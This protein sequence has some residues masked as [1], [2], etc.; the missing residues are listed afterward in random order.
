M[1]AFVLL[2]GQVDLFAQGLHDTCQ[3]EPSGW[4][5][6]AGRC[7]SSAH[8][9]GLHAPRPDNEVSVQGIM[10]QIH[11][12][13]RLRKGARIERERLGR[14]SIM[15]R[16]RSVAIACF[17]LCAAAGCPMDAS[18]GTH[19]HMQAHFDA[20]VAVRDALIAG[21]LDEARAK[22]RWI[23]ENEAEPGIASWGQYVAE[24]RERAAE[25]V[26]ASG[27]EAAAAASAEL[28]RACG[29]CHAGHAVP[30]ELGAAEPPPAASGRVPHMLRH[31]WAAE[32]MWEGL[33]GPSE[34]RWKTGAA[35]L[36]EAPLGS[37][38]ILAE[39]SAAPRITELADQV[40][41]LGEQARQ[42]PATAWGTRSAM[43]GRFLSTCAA[44]HQAVR[45]ARP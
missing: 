24:I 43:Y 42:I 33:I 9:L 4:A 16:I 44:C 17:S 7:G 3:R 30:P 18:A 26:N 38:E 39:Q 14:R 25:V 23:V 15:M 37:T 10:H 19:E 40:H 36:A 11:R 22:A 29:H 12:P 27:I 34:A 1:I 28:A 41:S 5:R 32:R 8:P 20:I 13:S 31:Q 45:P 2:K 21:S 35:E 6:E